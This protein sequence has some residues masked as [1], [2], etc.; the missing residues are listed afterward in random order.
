VSEIKWIKLTTDI[1][2]DEKI[3]LIEKMP[4]GDTL[5]IV[6]LKILTLAGKKNDCG[7]VYFTSSIPYTVE[8]LS[9]IFKRDARIISL[10]LNT[11]ISFEMIEI[12]DDIIKVLNWEK[13][14]NI[15]GMQKVR[16]Q[17]RER[18][19]K[20]RNSKKLEE[21]NATE[22]ES[23]GIDKIRIDKNRLDKKEK[24]KPA[25]DLSF[26]N[27][28][29]FKEVWEDF[30]SVRTKKKA[31]KSDRA[32]RSVVSK[33]KEYSRNNKEIAMK[34]LENS[35]DS[36]WPNVYELRQDK[37]T[38]AMDHGRKNFVAFETSEEVGG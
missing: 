33:L 35:A 20:F 12:E 15:E 21:C 36:G 13:H 34:I 11:F 38:Q 24:Y 27:D 19:R 4:E 16:E 5:L 3:Q 7:A 32:I 31:S 18:V 29:D 1:F 9:D 23:N 22:T 26:F 2:D 28:S 17:T 8:M 6:W 30:I 10:A 37:P 25:E 14:Q